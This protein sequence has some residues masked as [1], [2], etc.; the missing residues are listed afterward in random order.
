MLFP[1]QVSPLLEESPFWVMWVYDARTVI[2]TLVALAIVSYSFF[3]FIFG[4]SAVRFFIAWT[5]ITVAP[6]S[7]TSES[8]SWLNLNHLYLTSLSF[9]VILAATIRG[10]SNLLSRAGWRRFLPYGIAVYFVVLSLNLTYSL[11]DRH[12]EQATSPRIEALHEWLQSRVGKAA[13]T[14]FRSGP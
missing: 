6:F 10:T 1:L 7:G 8:G 2:R 3:G 9:C 11:D 5:F 14:V 12:R 13:R 4:N